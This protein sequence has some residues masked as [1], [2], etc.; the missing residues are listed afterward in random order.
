VNT[1]SISIIP[2]QI[3]QNEVI[4]SDGGRVGE[5]DAIGFMCITRYVTDLAAAAP[6]RKSP[7]Y[8]GCKLN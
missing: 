7:N 6:V 5:K 3:R 4:S 8:F 1:L 2:P